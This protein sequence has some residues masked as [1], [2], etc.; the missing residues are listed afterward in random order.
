MAIAALFLLSVMSAAWP[1][2]RAGDAGVGEQLREML[3]TSAKPAPSTD[4][5]ESL[6]RAFYAERDFRPAWS[7]PETVPAF[8]ASLYTLVNDGLHPGDYG[9]GRLETAYRH[10]YAM[11]TNAATRARFD[12]ATTRIYL[13]VLKSLSRGKVNPAAIDPHWS[14]HIAPFSPDM[15][16]LS[17]AVDALDFEGAFAQARPQ[18]AP[19]QRL[20]AALARYRAIQRNGGWPTLPPLVEPLRP[21]DSNP[22][23]AIVRRRLAAIGDPVASTRQ[24]DLYDHTLVDAVRR[25]Q[26]D[27]YLAVDGVV[28][29]KT[30]AALN[31]GVGE[32]IDQIRVNLERARWLLHGLP[33]SFVLVDIAGYQLSYYRPDGQIWRTRIVVGKPYRKTPSLRSKITYLTFNPTWTVPASITR[34]ELLPRLRHDPSYLRREHLRVLTP[35][36]KPIDPASVDWQRP[37]PIVLRQDAGPDDALGRV[38]FRFPNPYMVYLHDTP[39]QALFE[40]PRRAF[41]HGCMRVQHALEFARLLL[42]DPAHWSAVHI[43]RMVDA[44]VTRSVPLPKAVPVIVNYWTVNVAEDGE[45]AFK[46]DIY[47]RDRAL[48]KALNQPLPLL[49]DLP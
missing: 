32:R 39:A 18:Y 49:R 37:P 31:V 48:L 33:K 41:S 1:Q 5:L 16:K 30:R 7:K 12:I 20:R 45:L 35:S 4:D 3:Q 38:V 27:H 8:V 19:Y 14:V 23:V 15:R 10:A 24:P 28:G 21:G 29:A 36:G 6:V 44:G 2:V 26:R 34:R 22:D 13:D 43:R 42:N 9:A 40:R 47:H 17:Q 25:F 11:G 46:P